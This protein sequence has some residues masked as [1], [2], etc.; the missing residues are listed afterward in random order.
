[1]RLSD[2]GFIKYSFF[3]KKPLNKKNKCYNDIMKC[4]HYLHKMQNDKRRCIEKYLK[5]FAAKQ[6][7]GRLWQ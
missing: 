6:N 2:E 4:T 1:M 3:T 7:N 5:P